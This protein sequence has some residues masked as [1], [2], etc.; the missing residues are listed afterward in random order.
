MSLKYNYESNKLSKIY[1]ILSFIPIII[2]VCI[3]MYYA[4]SGRVHELWYEP[5]E[6]YVLYGFDEFCYTFLCYIIYFIPAMI[7]SFFY[8]VY[9]VVNKLKTKR[10]VK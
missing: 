2:L 4:I 10:G 9:Y 6:K 3:S 1:F 5:S 7:I 8:Q